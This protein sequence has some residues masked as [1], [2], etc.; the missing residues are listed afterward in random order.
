MAAVMLTGASTTALLGKDLGLDTALLAIEQV[1]LDGKRHLLSLVKTGEKIDADAVDRH[2]CAAHALAYV[3]TELE[4]CKQIVAW[5]DETGGS[6]ERSIAKAYVA[7][8][9]RML[10][11]SV[12]LGALESISIAELGV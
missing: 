11:S 5:A 1:F 2:Q 6:Y 9:A 10:R 12:E 8:V 7:E 3:A 4:A